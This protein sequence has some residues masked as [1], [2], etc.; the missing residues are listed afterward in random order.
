MLDRHMD[1]MDRC[2]Y[3]AKYFHGHLMTAEYGVR[4]WAL[5]HNFL[6]Y[7]PQAKSAATYQSPAH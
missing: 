7:G 5:L 1:R 6:P 4:S 3:R 2:F